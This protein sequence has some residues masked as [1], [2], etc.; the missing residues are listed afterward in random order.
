MA[1]Y[2]DREHEPNRPTNGVINIITDGLAVES[3]SNLAQKAYVQVVHNVSYEYKWPKVDKQIVFSNEDLTVVKISHDD[4]V[5]I[6]AVVVN[7]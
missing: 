5:V 4:A 2:K 1:E 6:S 3:E 7:F